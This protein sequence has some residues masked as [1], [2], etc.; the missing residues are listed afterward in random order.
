MLSGN[1]EQ[2]LPADDV[3]GLL[4]DRSE[5]RVARDGDRRPRRREVDDAEAHQEGRV[6][7]TRLAEEAS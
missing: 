5:E 7:A 2:N 4:R 3:R 6:L 1:L